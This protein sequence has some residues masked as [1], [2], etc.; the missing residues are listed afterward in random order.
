M[1]K[2]CTRYQVVFFVCVHHTLYLL[3]TV[4]PVIVDFFV[5]I[6]LWPTDLLD[7]GTAHSLA[8]FCD[9]FR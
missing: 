5:R 3:R 4:P 1:G 2:I 6:L 9:N 7:R 8:R